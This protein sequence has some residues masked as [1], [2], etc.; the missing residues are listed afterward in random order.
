[1]ITGVLKEIKD[2]QDKELKRVGIRGRQLKIEYNDLSGTVSEWCNHLGVSRYE[3]D[4]KRKKGFNYDEMIRCFQ[5]EADTRR[6][7]AKVKSKGGYIKTVNNREGKKQIQSKER[8]TRST[9][10]KPLKKGPYLIEYIGKSMSVQ[11]WCKYIQCRN[12]SFYKARSRLGSNERVID[13]FLAIKEKRKQKRIDTIE[14]QRLYEQ[15]KLNRQRLEV[16]YD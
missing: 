1:M 6:E 4:K 5:K 10:I 7:C 13:H 2:R 11:D 16:V 3:W 15:A 8:P 12:S 14:E 9:V